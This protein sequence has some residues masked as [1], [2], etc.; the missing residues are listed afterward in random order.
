VLL[1]GEARSCP[2][3]ATTVYVYCTAV[4]PLIG[5][6]SADRSHLREVTADDIRAGLGKLRGHQLCTTISAVRSLF[7]ASCGGVP[8]SIIKQ[9]IEQQQR[10]A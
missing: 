8:L 10:P 6:W 2:R 9:Y 7:A 1:D 5:R 4:E 3:S